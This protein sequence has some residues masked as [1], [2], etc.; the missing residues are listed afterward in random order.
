MATKKP[1]KS[2]EV[3]ELGVSTAK[4]GIYYISSSLLRG[5]FLFLVLIALV[6]LLSPN[7]YGLY[8]IAVAFYGV[9]EIIGYFGIGTA[10]RKR[11]PESN[12]DSK[13]SHVISGAYLI[14]GS[15][16]IVLAAVAYLLSG[17]I[18]AHVYSNVAL[19]QLFEIASITILADTLYNVGVSGL[20][21]LGKNS[22]AGISNVSYAFANLIISPTLVILGYGVM[23]A[24]IGNLVA[25]GLGA[26]ISFIYILRS[27]HL[28]LRLPDYEMIRYLMYFSLPVFISNLANAGVTNFGILFLGAYVTATVVGG[29]GAAYKLAS[30][31]SIIMAALTFVL[32]PAFSQMFSS[33]R[34]AK[35]ISDIYNGSLYY[36]LL[37]MLPLLAYIISV[38]YPLIAL[39]F[40]YTYS[41]T[42]LY[43]A[44]IAVGLALAIIGNFAGTLMI[45]HGS[46]GKYMLYELAVTVITLATMFA[47]VPS[48][49]ALGL[50][51]SF[52]VITPIVTNI[53]Y[54]RYLFS[55]FS[56]KIDYGPLIKILV[57][58][59]VLCVVLY[60]VSILLHQSR[61][62]VLI[63][64][65]VALLIFPPILAFFRGAEKSNIEF[66]RKVGS[67]MPFVKPVIDMYIGY[68]EHF[69][70]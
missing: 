64:G 57:A 70:R 37:L 22:G 27:M 40:S 18:A 28:K 23:G 38:S 21:G 31:I 11:L 10:L 60:G 19:T 15:M 65:V 13:R 63:N 42:S 8:T 35:R 7:D 9:I 3:T 43:F 1:S 6:R 53:I 46:V 55:K 30:F 56:F 66:A 67:R 29:F 47:L 44:V 58:S 39:L 2:S 25:Y 49:G 68:C 62:S 36:S 5:F 33:E 51:I 59:V 54:A 14:S 69:I 12:D 50:L 34:M 26:A 4:G 45:G 16:G 24:L 41:Y 17:Y 61:I 20:L 48:I 32:L 52:Y